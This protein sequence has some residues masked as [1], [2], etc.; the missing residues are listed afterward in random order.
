M[1]LYPSRGL[2]INGFE[3]T[4]SRQDWI[5][6]LKSPEKSAPVQRFCDRR[7]I[8]A[9]AGIIQPGELPPTWGQ[10]ENGGP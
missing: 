7:W 10:F 2:E 9:P 6:E 5:K 1:N 8:V 3:V 4:A